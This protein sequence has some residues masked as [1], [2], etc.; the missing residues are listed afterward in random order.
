MAEPETATKGVK[1]TFPPARGS[2]NWKHTRG[3]A[4]SESTLKSSNAEAVL[5]AQA[6]VGG[7]DCSVVIEA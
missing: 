4:E 7:A 5:G 3:D 2:E 1:S 6:L